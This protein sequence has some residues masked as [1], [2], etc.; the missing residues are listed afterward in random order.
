MRRCCCAFM[1]RL[2]RSSHAWVA[3]QKKP[4]QQD[5]TGTSEAAEGQVVFMHNA[6]INCHAIARHGCYG[7]LR[8]R[9]D[10]PGQPRHDCFRRS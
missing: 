10:S 1:R 2:P 7:P 5:F 8:A 6:C 9:P 3:Q 4:A